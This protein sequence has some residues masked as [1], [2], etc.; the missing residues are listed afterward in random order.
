MMSGIRGRDTRPERAIRSALHREG[1]RYRLY[2]SRVPGKPDL[3]FPAF[4][5]VIFVH[6][7]FWHG[8]DCDLFRLPDTRREFW[9]AKIERNRARDAEVSELLEKLGWRQLVIWECALRGQGKAA[10]ERVAKKAAQFLHSKRFK[11]EIRGA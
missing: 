10:V 4:N 8:H 11:M 6:G 7:C 5:A 3:V 9:K 2:S 1:L